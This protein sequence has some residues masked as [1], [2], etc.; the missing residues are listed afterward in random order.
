MKDFLLYIRFAI[1]YALRNKTL[2]HITYYRRWRKDK[3]SGDTTLSRVLPWMTYDAVDFLKEICTPGMRIFEWGSGGSTLFFASRCRQVTTIEHDSAWSGFL[4]EKFVELKLQNVD[5]K[6]IQGEKIDDFTTRNPENP[7]DFVS[8]D[9]KSAGLSFEKYVKSVDA[10]PPACF[11]MVIVDGR[12]RNCCVKRAIPHIGEG[13]FLVVDNSDRKY[14]LAAFPELNDPGK[15][16][17]TEFQGPVFFQHAFS[18]T[19][20]FRKL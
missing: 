17:K 15:W 14:Y 6:E 13:G 20:F 7:D 12:A 11:D 10:F 5:F 1:D 16:E 19:S 9:L 3:K 8:K 18:K 4:K 2:S